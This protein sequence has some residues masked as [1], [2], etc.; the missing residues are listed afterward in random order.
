M[1]AGFL[2]HPC[3][4]VQKAPHRLDRPAGP[5][6][7]GFGGLRKLGDKS[8]NSNKRKKVQWMRGLP[9]RHFTNRI[10]DPICEIPSRND[11]IGWFAVVSAQ[12]G[13]YLLFKIH[14]ISNYACR[15]RRLDAPPRLLNEMIVFCIL[16]GEKTKRTVN[17]CLLQREK[18]MRCQHKLPA[19]R[20]LHGDKTNNNNGG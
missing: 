8:K 20:F 13:R 15:G 9:R 7:V 18:R 14:E 17:K 6:G 19:A 16:H 1:P 10:A 2:F 11:K 3:K 12:C 5:G 4:S